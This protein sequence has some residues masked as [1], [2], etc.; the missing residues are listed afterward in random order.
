[1]SVE[2]G[3]GV[4]MF[5]FIEDL[6]AYFCKRYASYDKICM[7]KGYQ[8]PKRQTSEVR[9]GKTYAYTLPKE[10]L[11]LDFQENKAQMLVELKEKLLDKTF[12]FTF[13]TVGL[14]QKWK[15]R[16]FFNSAKQTLVNTLQKYKVTSADIQEGLEIDE[17]VWE[18]IVKGKFMPTKNLLFSLA[19]TAQF[20]VED[21]ER[22]LDAFDY[23]F[24]YAQAKDVVVRYLLEQKVHNA[25]MRAA[26]LKEYKIAHLFLKS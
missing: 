12:S 6:D 3:A 26:A 2:K 13:H 19:L 20:S 5:D 8:M 10:N 11:S 24:D 16:Q 9:N 1:M 7:L 18:N 15:Y 23:S 14:W 25:E 17:F 21:T 22:L 4:A